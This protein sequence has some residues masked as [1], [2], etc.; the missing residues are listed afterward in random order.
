LYFDAVKAAK[1]GHNK[2][3]LLNVGLVAPLPI[4][5]AYFPF[6]NQPDHGVLGSA[7]KSVQETIASMAMEIRT[8][9]RETLEVRGP[10]IRPNSR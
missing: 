5:T 7:S 4:I 2:P 10:T 8:K 6:L 1:M 3:F 9:R